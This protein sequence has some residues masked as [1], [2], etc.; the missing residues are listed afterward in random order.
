MD[1]TSP[2][3]RRRRRHRS[4]RAA[5]WAAHVATAVAVTGSAGVDPTRF[6]GIVAAIGAVVPVLGLAWHERRAPTSRAPFRFRNRSVV[7]ALAQGAAAGV[8]VGGAVGWL[9]APA[10]AGAL[11]LPAIAAF[12]ALRYPLSADLGDTGV[13]IRLRMRPVGSQPAWTNLN[14][15]TLTSKEIIVRA[16]PGPTRA[17]QEHIP[18]D[19]VLDVEV[20]PTV[21]D[22][23][24]W[25]ALE[26]FRLPTPAGDVVVVRHTDGR[27]ILPVLHAADFGAVA[28][29]R[30][31]AASPTPTT[32]TQSPHPQG[33]GRP[34]TPPPRWAAPIR[35][36]R[37][38]GATESGVRPC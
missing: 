23:D 14:S 2:A 15:V 13:E 18:L 25:F 10:V 27:R 16:Q 19:A 37:P 38:P 31:L 32:T 30:A 11:T 6:T 20:R 3:Q 33:P 21:P 26:D 22:D 12:R 24:P 29:A 28:R 34:R 8:V 36:P 35:A 1:P 5:A 4:W 7:V 17:Y 9:L